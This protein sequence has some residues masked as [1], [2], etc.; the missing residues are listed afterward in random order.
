MGEVAQQAFDF[1]QMECVFFEGILERLSD[2]CGVLKGGKER[3]VCIKIG[4]KYYF[5]LK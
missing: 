5:Q 1:H 4:L 3:L 2:L